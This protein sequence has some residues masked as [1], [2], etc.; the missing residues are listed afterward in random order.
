MKSLKHLLA[1]GC[2]LAAGQAGAQNVARCHINDVMIDKGTESLSVSFTFHPEQYHINRNNLLRITPAVTT[3]NDTARL[4]PLT[5]TGK[6]AW[7]QQIR[8]GGDDALLFRASHG[9]PTE[10]TGTVAWEPW[11]DNSTFT[12]LLDTVSCCGGEPKSGALR[13]ARLDWR[14]RLFEPVFEYVTPADTIVKRFNLSGRADVRFIV[15]KTDIDWSY[16]NNHA[17][18]DSIMRT[19]RVVRNN[20]DAAVDSIILTGYASPEGPYANNVRLARGRTEV[21]KEYVRNHGDF[22]ASV[23]HTASVPEDW[24]GLCRWLADSNL[25]ERMEM[26]RFID[27]DNGPVETKNDRFAAAFPAQYP[28]LL[29]NVYP[30]LRHTDYRITYTVRRY[31]EVEEILRVFNTYPGN[32]SLNELFVLANS[33][34]RGTKEFD[35]VM[36]TAVLLYPNDP[37]ANLNAANASMQTGDLERA[38]RLLTK[39]GDSAEA[40]YARGVLLGRQKRYAEARRCF[41]KAARMGEKQAQNALR[42]LK[43]LETRTNQPVTFIITEETVE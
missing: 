37:V 30:P 38:E 14:P 43:E 9:Q 7:Y 1:A 19:V 21:I 17:E 18:L 6:Y 16:A 25:P 23:Y 31:Y 8:N 5:V 40:E 33:Y 10:Y 34:G 4:A 11:M 13:V 3:D 20:P 12:L 2:L 22:P 35:E 26:I 42:L 32:L 15:N 29:T 39:A 36:S 41:E 24:E 27:A 28:W